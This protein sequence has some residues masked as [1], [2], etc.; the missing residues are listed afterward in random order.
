MQQMEAQ[1]IY[2]HILVLPQTSCVTLGKSPNLSLSPF[3]LWIK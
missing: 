3:P 1:E 2:V